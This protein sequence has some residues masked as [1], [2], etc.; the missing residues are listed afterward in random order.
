MILLSFV[1]LAFATVYGLVVVV[2]FARDLLWRL[3][4]HLEWLPD[5]RIH[6]AELVV[7]SRVPVPLTRLGVLSEFVSLLQPNKQT[8]TTLQCLWN[9]TLLCDDRRKFSELIESRT[10]HR[11]VLL[12]VDYST[13][14]RRRRLWSNGHKHRHHHT[15][16]YSLVGLDDPFTFPPY[17]P[18]SKEGDAVPKIGTRRA[19]LMLQLLNSDG[20]LA[21]QLST[22]VTSAVFRLAGPHNDFFE[23]SVVGTQL[24]APFLYALLHNDV[25]GLLERA[26]DHRSS[27]VASASDIVPTPTTL[28]P[29]A[30]VSRKLSLSLRIHSAGQP[31]R[32][33]DMTAFI[34]Q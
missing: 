3:A 9:P 6:A 28:K 30:V 16:F 10:A 26:H 34:R 2:V 25:H 13:A 32:V 4:D 15:V 17:D 22:D 12:R 19:I 21:H 5:L 14:D 11:T 27:S 18:F 1:P 20:K 31:V 8:T 33:T 7:P 23:K 24:E 29:A